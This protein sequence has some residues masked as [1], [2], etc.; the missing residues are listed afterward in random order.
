MLWGAPSDAAALLKHRLPSSCACALPGL[1]REEEEEEEEE[2]NDEGEAPAWE[3]ETHTE[4]K[5]SANWCMDT[6]GLNP[7]PAPTLALPTQLHKWKKEPG[8][9]I[10]E[11]GLLCLTN[12]YSFGF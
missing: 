4:D 1:D 9:L 8:K 11:N 7:T 2:K 12:Y 3:G 6:K 5:G 10:P